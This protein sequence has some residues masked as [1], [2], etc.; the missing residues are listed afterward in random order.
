[1]ATT[2][3]LSLIAQPGKTTP[4]PF[5]VLAT[6]LA[7][8]SSSSDTVNIE[9]VHSLPEGAN[10]VQLVMDGKTALGPIEAQL[11]LANAFAP[12]RVFGADSDESVQV[13]SWLVASC[14]ITT[15][16]LSLPPHPPALPTALKLLSALEQRLT[17]RT[18]LVGHTPT[19]V[20]YAVWG[21]LR[22]NPIALGVLAKPGVPHTARWYAHLSNLHPCQTAVSTLFQQA[23]IKAPSANKSDDKKHDGANATFELGLPNA[24]NGQVVTRLPPEPSGYLHIG[25]AKAA[26]LNQY[27]ARMYEGHFLIRFDDTNPSKEKAEFEQSIIQDLAL[28]GVKADAT[29][30]TSDYFDVLQRYCVQ[31]IKQ[32]NA[33]AD[34]TEQEKMRDQR[35]NGIPSDRRDTSVEDNLA[36]FA[37]MATGSEEGRRWCIRAKISVDDPNKAMRDPV[38]YRCNLLPH[39]RTGT[40]YKMYPTYDFCC[41]IVDSLQGVTHALRTNEYRDRNPQ[42]QWMLTT[43]GLRPVEVWDFGRLAFVYTLLSKRKLKWF[44]EQGH[45]RGWD[46]PRFATVR[47]I[48]R[49]GMTIEALTQFMLMQGPSQAFT[50]LEWDVFWSLNKK[51]IDPVAPRFTALEKKDLVKVKIMGGEGLPTN[52]PESKSMPKHKKNAQV[53][54]KTTW[55]DSTIYVEQVDAITFAQDEEITLM[56]WGNAFVRSI[57]RDAPEGKVLDIEMEL[58]LCGDFKK[59]KKKITWLASPSSS[60]GLEALTK[61]TLLDY[62]YLIFKKKMEDDDKFEDWLTP[63]TEFRTE[64]YADVNVAGLEKGTIIQFERKGFFIVDQSANEDGGAELILIPDGKVSTVV[65]KHEAALLAAQKAKN[66]EGEPKSG[67]GKKEDKNAGGTSQKEGKGA[68]KKK[69]VETVTATATTNAKGLPDIAPEQ[70][71]E[72]I[73]LSDGKEGFEQKVF[74]KMFK[75]P[76]VYGEDG[77]DAPATTKMFAVKPVYQQ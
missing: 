41:P 71:K 31:I 10:A 37:E 1:M 21:H 33:Y 47:G 16:L 23:K 62:D 19:V 8:P 38:I 43:L 12:E 26:I 52:G 4:Q 24:I 11:A 72:S 35:M 29:S 61:V 67:K 25:H 51:V 7:L 74:T 17:L 46:D 56:D 9:W 32:G 76:S 54:D 28:L 66:G 59:T 5:G 40:K 57:Q 15:L 70:A 13:G 50:N 45:V 77:V 39:H 34:D 20:D 2:T 18:Y 36:H 55:F 6:A 65:S 53:G 14:L 60:Q 48:R 49:R 44:V 30:Y 75:V 68:E 42:Y 3:T 27:F 64:A 58:N 63:Q 22:A 73:L 69:K